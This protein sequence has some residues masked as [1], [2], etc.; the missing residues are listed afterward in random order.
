MRAPR[1]FASRDDLFEA[2]ALRVAAALEA[3]IAARGHGGA[4]LSGGTTPEP[5]YALLAARPLD[6]P[7]VT[8]ALVDERLV[9]PD[10]PASN[11]AL[12][13]RSLAKALQAGARLA[14]MYAPGPP[15]LAATRADALYAPL[16][17]DIAVLGM[18]DD[19]HTAS[20]FPQ[21]RELGAALDLANPRTVVRV[22]AAGA[23]GSDDR[24]TL[25]RA[26]L[27][28][29]DAAVL[30]IAGAEK[31]SALGTALKTGAPVAALVEALGDKLET[32]WAA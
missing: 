7:R 12:V 1:T 13:R 9:P 23:A 10:H 18:G 6:W 4:A 8:F 32:L 15:D 28:R 19:G 29:A 5:V 27:A 26:A 3:G 21:S 25:T 11:E 17:F 31:F 20:W 22:H 24:L 30:L 14:P 16:H 2:A